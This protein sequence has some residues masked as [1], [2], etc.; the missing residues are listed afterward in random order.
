MSG[1]YSKWESGNISAAIQP[2]QQ[3]EQIFAA[4]ALLLGPDTDYPKRQRAAQRLAK[5]G[6]ELLPLLLYTLH[7]CPPIT[8]PGW[9]WWPPQYEQTSRL[10]IQLSQNAHLSLED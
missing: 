10:L 1:E 4:L 3:Q 5:V 6:P 7:I 8:V 9:P 2:L